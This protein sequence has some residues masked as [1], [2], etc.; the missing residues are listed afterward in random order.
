VVAQ[1]WSAFESPDVLWASPPCPNFSV[2]KTSRGETDQDRALAAATLSAVS[3]LQPQAFVLENVEG[4]RKSEGFQAIVNELYGLGYWVE[5]S[6][7][8]AA[9][10]GV[11]QTRRRLILR[12]KKGFLA[13]LPEPI[14]WVGWYEAIADL[15]DDLPESALAQWQVDRLPAGVRESFL[16]PATDRRSF[17][18]RLGHE[19][20]RSIGVSGGNRPRAVLFGKN[21]SR[22]GVGVGMRAGEEPF[23]TVTTG[24][25]GRL[26]AL[27]FAGS[28]SDYRAGSKPGLV[29]RA[30]EEPAFTI[31][32]SMDRQAIRA[33]TPSARTVLLSPR[34]LARL[35]SVPDLYLL[36][37]SAR[38][39]CVVIGNGVPCRMARAIIE[40][41]F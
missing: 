27:L 36:P 6:V 41:L 2:A 1:D 28:Q 34:C 10:F 21:T 15:I 20:A 12:A 33:L 32:K 40:S 23:F 22:E 25:D 16:A 29:I 14:Q 7:V 24:M 9:D 8:N 18:I 35:Q 17:S 3:I 39:A 37:D 19:P 13:P 5:W 26:R 38:L 30:G 4:Y 31:T 11:P